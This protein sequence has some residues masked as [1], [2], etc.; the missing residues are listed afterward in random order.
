M[1]YEIS[2]QAFEGPLD[3]LLHLI[4][5]NK[6][7]IYDIPMTLVTDQYIAHLE[8]MKDLDMEVASD[9]LLT[10]STLLAIKAKMLLPK[11][12]EEEEEEDPRLELV[13][14]LLEYQKYKSVVDIF[15]TMEKDN[16][17]I[18]AKPPDEELIQTL[19]QGKNPLENVLFSD[20]TALFQELLDRVDPEE[21][22]REIARQPLT[23]QDV[24]VR[25]KKQLEETEKLYFHQ[26]FTP[27]M[28]RYEL[29]IYFLSLLELLRQGLVEARQAENCGPIHLQLIREE[30]P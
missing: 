25:I 4:R 12:E 2:L 9:F 18:Y 28:G 5:K 24:L 17:R 21:A 19:A 8:A 14:R 6:I 22:S 13:S 1:A 29:V 7:D 23:I 20:L 27:D 10:A 15:Q 11:H 3:L 30:R 26:V 16:A